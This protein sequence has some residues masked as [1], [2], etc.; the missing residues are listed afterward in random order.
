MP[1]NTNIS[2]IYLL[3]ETF[4]YDESKK[5]DTGDDEDDLCEVKPSDDPIDNGDDNDKKD[6][7]DDK[8]DLCKVEPSDDPLDELV[9]FG[10]RRHPG[11]LLGAAGIV[12]SKDIEPRQ[13]IEI[14]TRTKTMVTC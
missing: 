12:C 4:G 14:K 9:L 3:T 10:Q 1:S 13:T 5:E 7:Y 2:H 8:D 11:H 6:E